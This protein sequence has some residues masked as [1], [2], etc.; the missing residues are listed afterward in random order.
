MSVYTL[1]TPCSRMSV[2]RGPF[3]TALH[4]RHGLLG[5]ALPLADHLLSLEAGSIGPGEPSDVGTWVS[6]SPPNRY[7]RLYFML[8][9]STIHW[10]GWDSGMEGVLLAVNL[11]QEPSSDL[12]AAIVPAPH[13]GFWGSLKG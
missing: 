4:H 9:P 2:Q 1:E 6:H 12:L 11:E 3:K 10:K 7:V 8:K 13:S 5:E